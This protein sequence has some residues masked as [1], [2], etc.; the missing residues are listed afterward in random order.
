MKKL[1]TFA[2]TLILVSALVLPVLAGEFAPGNLEDYLS[3]P[4]HIANGE[5]CDLLD[6]L[7]L[8][9]SEKE[10]LL[11][12][13]EEIEE[14]DIKVTRQ[15]K[16]NYG[17][18]YTFSVEKYDICLESVVSNGRN[19]NLYIS[20]GKDAFPY[21]S[22]ELEEYILAVNKMSDALDLYMNK[23]AV[24]SEFIADMKSYL[25]E[26]KYVH[27]TNSGGIIEYSENY[28]GEYG[29]R[30]GFMSDYPVTVTHFMTKPNQIRVARQYVT[31][32][33][34]EHTEMMDGFMFY[35]VSLNYSTPEDGENNYTEQELESIELDMRFHRD[36]APATS[37]TTAVYAAVAALALGVV[38]VKKKH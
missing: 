28:R 11:R 14:D 8:E 31:Q 6:K 15:Y 16:E 7:F 24:D 26:N 10:K 33:A 20:I 1:L 5:I 27:L 13:V 17:T 4:T 25:D 12:I 2:L 32:F 21:L 38:V 37:L 3:S 22:D 34:W 35:D 18:V 23:E 30:S 29:Y 19:W 9:G 36:S